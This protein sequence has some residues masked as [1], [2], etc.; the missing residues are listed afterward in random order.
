MRK[1]GWFESGKRQCAYAGLLAR[2]FARPGL[3]QDKVGVSRTEQ[4][5]PATGARRMVPELK[6]ARL[7]SGSLGANAEE[8]SIEFLSP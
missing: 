3:R 7:V 1:E 4:I 6:S 5:M 8:A 2:R